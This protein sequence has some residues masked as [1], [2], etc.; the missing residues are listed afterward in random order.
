MPLLSSHFVNSVPF[1]LNLQ[2]SYLIRMFDKTEEILRAERLQRFSRAAQF[3]T[4]LSP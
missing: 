2:L 3:I 4:H 1:M